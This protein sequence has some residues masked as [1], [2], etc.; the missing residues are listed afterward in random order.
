MYRIQT[1]LAL[2]ILLA[3]VGCSSAK[4]PVAPP[5]N[6]QPVLQSTEYQSNRTVWGYWNI[7]IDPD[8]ETVEITPDRQVGSHF[9][10]VR[11]LEV[12][13]CDYCIKVGLRWQ[14]NNIVRADIRLWHPYPGKDKFSGF[15]VR[16]V[17]VTHGDTLFPGSNRLV[18]LDGSNPILI[19]PDGFTSLFNPTEF[20]QGSSPGP[21]LSYIPGKSAIG[22]YFTATLNPYK[23][24]FV[25]NP[26]RIFNAPVY[27]EVKYYLKYPSVPFEIGYVVDVSWM[28][29]GEVNNP[30]Y[31]F[32]PEANCLEP[33]RL[34]FQMSSVLTDQIG[35]TS[36]VMVKVFDHQGLDTLGAVSIECPQLFE[37]EVI[38]DYSSQAGDDSW[39]FSGII[40][41]QYGGSEGENPSLLKVVSNESDSNLGDLAA[42]Q[43]ADIIV[44]SGGNLIWAQHSGGKNGERGLGI[45]TLSDDSTVVTGLFAGSATFGEGEANEAVLVSAGSTDIL[46]ARYNPDSTL[47]WAKRAGGTE[48]DDGYGMTSLSDDSI[49]VTGRFQDL[50]TFGEGEANETVLASGDSSEIFVAMYNPDGTLEW[51]KRVIG[52]SHNSGYGITTL[53]DDST[54]VTGYFTEF[55]IFGEGEA[56]ETVLV[57]AGEADIF[58]ARYNID[59]TLAWAKRAGGTVDYGGDY[60]YAITTLFDDSTVVTGRFAGSATFGEGEANETVIDSDGRGYLFVARYKP[61]GNLE[62]VRHAGGTLYVTGNG[63]T[64]LSDDS[65][66]VTGRLAG[67]AT[68]GKGE[69]NETTLTADGPFD[70]FLAR[71]NP[72]GTLAWAKKSGGAWYDEGMGITA[73][74]DDST[75]VTGRFFDV[76]IFGEGEPNETVLA[77]ATGRS[78]FVARL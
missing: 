19:N 31:D 40:T 66:V 15:D 77:S 11:L 58:V 33:Y 52:T 63:I 42:Y 57:S 45:T 71:Y 6:Q 67:S 74:S 10:V 37:G 69:P 50:A 49:V 53:S 28:K 78:I 30:I 38:L 46:V 17:V 65:F 12:D 20:P 25:D 5:E 51:A 62:W 73:L 64:K 21:A 48:R 7:R 75:V 59:G 72:D 18:S 24:Y 39:I 4:S 27:E 35:A 36:E 16:G 44:G 32:P 9:N 68:F 23:A 47:Y 60:S 29:V 1:V 3:V 56:N 55:A 13:P 41:N 8:A 2:I 26:R 14:P 70:I 34:D 43:V 76:A 61:D 54:V 22:D